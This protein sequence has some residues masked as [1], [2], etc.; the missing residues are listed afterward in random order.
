MIRRRLRAVTAGVL[1]ALT[2]AGALVLAVTP[3]SAP[4]AVPF[5]APLS[6]S[7]PGPAS[8]EPDHSL[9]GFDLD[10]QPVPIW[11]LTN[12]GLGIPDTVGIGQPFAASGIRAYFSTA[13]STSTCLVHPQHWVYGI[14]M[15]T[16]RRL[17]APFRLPGN[18]ANLSCYQTGAA[19]ALCL[20][21]YQ[22][23]RVW[24]L[25][26]TAGTV[27]Y[28]GETSLGGRPSGPDRYA[29][30][31]AGNRLVAGQD[32]RGLYGI[33]AHGQR[34]WFFPG[35]G[36]P[37]TTDSTVVTQIPNPDD[38]RWRVFTAADGTEL[39]PSPPAGMT[40][41]R[42]TTYPGGF[43]YQYEATDGIG[44]LFY[45]TAGTLLHQQPLPGYNLLD[46]VGV[47]VVFDQSTFHVF[48][49]AGRRIAEIPAGG[50]S[51]AVA[52]QL[53][54]VGDHLLYKV[55]GK[56][57]WQRWDLVT[58]QPG[59]TCRI[60]LDTG[61]NDDFYIGSDGRVV[62]TQNGNDV[63]AIE[64]DSCQQLWSMPVGYRGLERVGSALVKITSS[65]IVGLGPPVLRG[66]QPAGGRP[67]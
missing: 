46:G 41:R 36:W 17:F 26:L 22:P 50:L 9:I 15:T 12:A 20:D 18:T 51:D 19:T 13:C 53:R 11:H 59:P 63:I 25:D 40:L 47:P 60:P 8:I 54:R 5:S 10:R 29:F 34:T 30:F 33:D 52:R 3:C 64:L 57:E 38:P 42:A 39:T 37:V 7:T 24:A 23:D 32:E 62:L 56:G 27:S 61:D 2:I 67:G 65:E 16:G 43:A 28:S 1:V 14:D 4:S 49:A 55:G 58:G 45:N 48:T 35:D 44:V 31:V 66:G 6:T 21:S